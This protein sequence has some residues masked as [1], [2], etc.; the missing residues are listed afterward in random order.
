MLETETTGFKRH[1]GI[2]EPVQI[3]AILYKDGRESQRRCYKR[4][5]LTEGKTEQGKMGI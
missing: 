3:V 5:F 4:Y 1:A 2:D